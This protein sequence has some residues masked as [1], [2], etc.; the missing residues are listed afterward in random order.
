MAAI[1]KELVRKPKISEIESLIDLKEYSCQRYRH[2]SEW[3]M[4]CIDCSEKKT[5]LAGKQA[6]KLMETS[7]APKAKENKTEIPDPKT[8]TRGYIAYIFSLKEPVKELLK[9]AGNIRPQSVYARVNLWRKNYPDL[10]EKYNMIEK[11]RFLW[12]KPYNS[13]R[14]ED[15]LKELFPD[16]GPA[17][18][19]N[20]KYANYQVVEVPEKTIDD[21]LEDVSM[22]EE[23]GEITLEDFLKKNGA[24][25]SN[26]KICEKADICEKPADAGDSGRLDALLE[27]LRKNIT[28]YERKIQ[29]TKE[30]IAA[31]L[32]V[33]K[34][35]QNGV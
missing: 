33:Q 23:S 26:T 29:E 11:V 12:T 13:M 16:E 5:C 24:P 25:V 1:K 27:K 9:T 17:H 34:L 30:Q 7:T 8:D 18:D 19:F 15:I 4:N 32:T 28:E 20:G 3:Y 31:V 22:P 6:I 21:I 2:M 35:M 10:E 14:I